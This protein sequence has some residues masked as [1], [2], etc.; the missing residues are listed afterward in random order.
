MAIG[1]VLYSLRFAVQP[2]QEWLYAIE[3]V[4]LEMAAMLGAEPVDH[5]FSVLLSCCEAA[6]CRRRP[7]CSLTPFAN[8]G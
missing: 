5:L 8:S 1:S 4:P 7:S 6:C 3:S 2:R